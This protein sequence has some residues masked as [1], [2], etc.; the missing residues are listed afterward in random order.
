M[1]EIMK[2]IESARYESDEDDVRYC[3]T[4]DGL[5]ELVETLAAYVAGQVS[6]GYN[7]KPWIALLLGSF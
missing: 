3:F 7:I 6:C 5:G 4:E 1:E 2:L